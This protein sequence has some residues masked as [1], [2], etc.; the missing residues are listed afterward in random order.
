[1]F[2]SARTKLSVIPSYLCKNDT[3]PSFFVH[4]LPPSPPPPPRSPP[5]RTPKY[6][7]KFTSLPK[8][9]TWGWGHACLTRVKCISLRSFLDDGSLQI[10]LSRFHPI[11]TS[12]QFS[13]HFR[14]QNSI[15]LPAL[16]FLFTLCPYFIGFAV[17]VDTGGRQFITVRPRLRCFIDKNYADWL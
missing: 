4:S 17:V 3:D 9:S 10:C 6:H 12:S 11:P 8:P 15:R 16:C 1:M 7:S 13:P 14:F 2:S 5:S